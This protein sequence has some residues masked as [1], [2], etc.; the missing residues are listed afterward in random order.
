MP[1][2]ILIQ[3]DFL[4]PNYVSYLGVDRI[5]VHV[6]QDNFFYVDEEIIS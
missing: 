1:D 5:V 2:Y 6:L 4:D 3:L